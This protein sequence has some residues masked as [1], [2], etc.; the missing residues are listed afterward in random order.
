MNHKF[1]S[2]SVAALLIG[3][4]ACGNQ[5]T[6]TANVPSSQPVQPVVNKETNNKN[7]L[8]L[9]NLQAAYNGESNAHN[10]YLAFAKKAEQ[11]GYKQVVALFKAAAQAEAIHAANHAAVIREMGGN[12]EAKI[13]P[14]EVKSTQENLQAAIKGES[15]ERDTMYPQFIAEA[16]KEGN[17]KAVMTFTYAVT[18]ETEHAKYYTQ[19]KDNLTDWK[20][21]KIKFY[22]CPECG[23]TTTE[24]SFENCPECNT[25]KFLFGEVI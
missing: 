16:K 21:A 15:Y 19:A 18:A 25:A 2:L 8:S 11:E 23:F 6:P 22:V 3:L 24:L 9:K 7:S 5:Q 13:E 1:L 12:P 17:N 20:E 14:V 4:T 10:R